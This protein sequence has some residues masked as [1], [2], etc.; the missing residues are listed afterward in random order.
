M[1]LLVIFGKN[2]QAT[3]EV[4]GTIPVSLS[5]ALLPVLRH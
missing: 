5:G 3:L 1:A 4:Q 2:Y